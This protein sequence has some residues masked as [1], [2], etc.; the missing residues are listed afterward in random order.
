MRDD[1]QI[2]I[3]D[4]ALYVRG[5]LSEVKISGSKKNVELFSKVLSESR[6]FYITLQEGNLKNVLPQLAK[7]RQASKALRE[8]TGY[9]WPL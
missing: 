7:K 2:F 1:Q 4:C 5:E 8:Q 3:R 6:K 9:V